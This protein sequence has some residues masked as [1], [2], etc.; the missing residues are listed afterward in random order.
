MKLSIREYSN[1]RFGSLDAASIGSIS[2]CLIDDIARLTGKDIHEVRDIFPTSWIITTTTGETFVKISALRSLDPEKFE[3]SLL[4]G[5]LDEIERDLFADYAAGHC[6]AG[7]AAQTKEVPPELL[8]VNLRRLHDVIGG[9]VD[10][11]TFMDGIRKV[12]DSDQDVPYS[13]ILVLSDGQWILS[14]DLALRLTAEGHSFGHRMARIPIIEAVFG[15]HTR[16]TLD[17]AMKLVAR[18]LPDQDDRLDLRMIYEFL[19][20]NRP[21]HVWEAEQ[22]KEF[23]RAW[24]NESAHFPPH[25]F[26]HEN[27]NENQPVRV[28]SAS[29]RARQK[30]QSGERT[31]A[32]RAMLKRQNNINL[33]GMCGKS[34]NNVPPAQDLGR[35]MLLPLSEAPY[36]Q[37]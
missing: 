3:G 6:L 5:W 1:E 2:Y 24:A 31:H 29:V 30:S 27:Q 9:G 12:N 21:Y 37:N 10:F 33:D 22:N 25:A 18:M 13:H 28:R 23:N 7:E 16:E 32:R 11:A 17:D 36:H 15:E 8:G 14:L 4:G 35:S 19:S 34:A 26:N 20:E